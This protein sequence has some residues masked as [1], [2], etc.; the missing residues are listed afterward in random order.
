MIATFWMFITTHIMPIALAGAGIGLLITIHE[1]GHFIF[2][3]LFNIGVPVF[4]IGFGPSL[5]KKKIGATEFRLSLIPLGGYCAIQGMSDPEAGMVDVGSEPTDPAQDFDHKALWQKI[6]VMLGGIAF[7]LLFA[8]GIFI[9]LHLGTRPR[10][11]T[12]IIAHSIA[13]DSPAA[14]A[15]PTGSRILGYNGTR[16]GASDQPVQ[17]EIQQFLATI[18]EHPNEAL[19]L[20]LQN[21]TDTTQTVDVI[22]G[23]NESGCGFLGVRMEIE[24]KAVANET[25]TDSLS[26]ALHKGIVLA[27]F[28]I[29]STCTIIPSLFKKRSLDGLGGPL[30]LFRQA[31]KNAQQGLRSLWQFLGSFSITLAIMNL[32]PLGALDGGQLLFVLIEGIIRRKLPQRLKEGIIIASW[33]L[34]LCLV[35]LLSYRDIIA[36]IG[37]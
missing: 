33:L 31:F 22:L 1:C 9:A 15:I 17:A 13:A 25:E 18:A 26:S 16:F 8:Y 37:Y 7:N 5:F 3:R 35:L 19:S 4:S 6:A 23:R 32:I 11:Q 34:F 27:N 30:T 36:L 21:E 14:K 24:Q 29:K 20:T 28:F 12:T 10:M 2:A